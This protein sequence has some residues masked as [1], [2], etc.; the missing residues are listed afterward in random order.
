MTTEL[1]FS[2]S[3][4]PNTAVKLSCQVPHTPTP[5]VATLTSS[6]LRPVDGTAAAAAKR[7]EERAM[8]LN[9]AECSGAWGCVVL[10]GDCYKK[11]ADRAVSSCVE[12]ADLTRRRGHSSHR[13]WGLGV[14]TQELAS[15]ESCVH[16]SM[17]PTTGTGY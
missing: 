12:R 3:T 17:Y 10:V 13:H 6:L 15:L 4:C 16:V 8:N 9:M 2:F 1:T 7:A 14:R 11:F 5:F